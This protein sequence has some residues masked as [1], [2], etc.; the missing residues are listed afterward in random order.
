MVVLWVELRLVEGDGSFG[1]GRLQWLEV[2][3]A[4]FGILME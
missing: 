1:H 3:F 4:V 2:G